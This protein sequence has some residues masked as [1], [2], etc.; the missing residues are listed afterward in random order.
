[1]PKVF[2][3]LPFA[4]LAIASC[5]MSATRTVAP[6]ILAQAGAASVKEIAGVRVFMTGDDGSI[7]LSLL[8]GALVELAPKTELRA[9]GATLN[10]NGNRLAESISRRLRLDLH[11]GKISALIQFETDRSSVEITFPDGQLT[12]ETP[13]LFSVEATSGR[14]KIICARGTV[15]IRPPGTEQSIQLIGP[16]FREWPATSE[17]AVPVAFDPEATEQIEKLR[18]LERKLLNSERERR[19]TPHPWRR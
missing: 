2:W 16:A 14:A 6:V 18:A 9:D 7:A 19:L 12:V 13:A 3:A 15:S 10:K 4:T 17:P 8:P 11:G 5:D 1:M